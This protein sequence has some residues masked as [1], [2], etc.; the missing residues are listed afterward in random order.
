MAQRILDAASQLG[1]KSRD[2]ED[3][4]PQETKCPPIEPDVDSDEKRHS[5]ELIDVDT[6]NTVGSFKSAAEARAAQ[7]EDSVVVAFDE[8]GVASEEKRQP[9]YRAV[10]KYSPDQPRDHGRFAESEGSDEPSLDREHVDWPKGWEPGTSDI[11]KTQEGRLP[12][13]FLRNIAMTFEPSLQTQREYAHGDRWE[14]FKQDIAQNGVKVPIL[15]MV[16]DP[17]DE[18]RPAIQIEGQRRLLASSELGLRTVPVEV[19]YFGITGAPGGR[20]LFAEAGVSTERSGSGELRDTGTAEKAWTAMDADRYDQQEQQRQH[21]E[22]YEPNRGYGT[23]L[24][25]GATEWRHGGGPGDVPTVYQVKAVPWTSLGDTAEERLANAGLTPAAVPMTGS[26][27]TLLG[28]QKVEGSEQPEPY[29]YRIMSTDEFDQARERGYFQSDQNMNLANEGTVASRGSTGEFYMPMRYDP[30]TGQTS[31]GGDAR[32]VQFTMD[33]AHGWKLG[34][35]SYVKT[36]ERVPFSAVAAY[37]EPI[38]N[39]RQPKSVRKYSPDQPRDHGRFADSEGGS[40]DKPEQDKPMK[41]SRDEN[42]YRS[43]DW[44]IQ[45]HVDDDPGNLFGSQT[46][47]VL[48]DKDPQGN[49]RPIEVHRTLADAKADAQR[50]QRQ[51]DERAGK[52]TYER[53]TVPKIHEALSVFPRGKPMIAGYTIFGAGRG[54][55]SFL[56]RHQT[57]GWD[58]VS[59]DDQA[60]EARSAIAKYETALDSASIYHERVYETPGVDWPSIQVPKEPPS[61]ASNEKRQPL[62]ASASTTP[63]SRATTKASGRPEAEAT[64]SSRKTRAGVP[65]RSPGSGLVRVRQG[66][67]RSS[68]GPALGPFRGPSLLPGATLHHADRS[69]TL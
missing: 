20:N 36:Q 39:T 41:W 48:H 66:A 2:G 3:L 28:L 69:H 31:P 1:L 34:T 63:T 24:K 47:W 40:G 33:P 51:R 30:S 61:G 45:K 27:G 56:V 15:V 18:G 50:L 62:H 65:A 13:D 16:N 8:H 49:D 58:R 29:L 55:S 4:K 32:I 35:D 11:G 44:F 17:R 25:E 22:N 10:R 21:P 60:S 67:V 5:Y 7:D 64:A 38:K 59:L 12:T 54:S 53:P 37:S 46:Q 19:R 43:G 68:S 42:G 26:D 6:G 14:K 9:R 23:H 52:S 57:S